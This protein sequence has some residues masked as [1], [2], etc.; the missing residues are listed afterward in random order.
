[1]NNENISLNLIK[2]KVF[3]KRS[4][5]NHSVFDMRTMYDFNMHAFKIQLSINYTYVP[6]LE[7]MTSN[8]NLNPNPTVSHNP[9]RTRTRKCNSVMFDVF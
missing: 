8:K 7:T 1:M 5:L 6:N 3:R 9:N 4:W 2:C